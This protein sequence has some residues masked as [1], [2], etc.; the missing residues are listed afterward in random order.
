MNRGTGWGPVERA[1]YWRQELRE[2]WLDLRVR[3][4]Q[5]NW[6]D[7]QKRA[8]R[9]QQLDFSLY[10]SRQLTAKMMWGINAAACRWCAYIAKGAEDERAHLLECHPEVVSERMI[11]AGYRQVG[12]RWVDTLAADD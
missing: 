6:T 12:D 11:A 2:R 4:Q 9:S 8:W 7:E 5:R 1:R 3:W 10:L